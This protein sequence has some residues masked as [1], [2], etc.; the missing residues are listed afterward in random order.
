MTVGKFPRTSSDAK[1]EKKV[2]PSETPVLRLT[3]APAKAV[4]GAEEEGVVIVDI[5]PTGR[6]AE[7]G[8]QIGDIIP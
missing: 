1:A 2:M 8:L 4:A 3:L 7:S 6:A 5:S